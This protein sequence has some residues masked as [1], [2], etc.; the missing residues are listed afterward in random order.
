M[1]LPLFSQLTVFLAHSA[2]AVK[3]DNHFVLLVPTS[4][5]PTL[6]APFAQPPTIAEQT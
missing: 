1:K 6:T 4:T 5:Q 2:Q 3:R